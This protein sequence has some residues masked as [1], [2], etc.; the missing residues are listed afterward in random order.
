[1]RCPVTRPPA[2][3]IVSTMQTLDFPGLAAAADDWDALVARTPEID[4]FCTSSAWIVSA[5]AAFCPGARPCIALDGQRGVALM[6]LPV[7]VDTRGGL[8]LEAGWGLAAPLVGP[9][10]DATVALL[11]GLWRDAPD[12]M[13]VL[14]L[15]GLPR[16]GRWMDALL[17]R[18][19]GRFR[20]GV[21]TRCTR[22]RAH[23]GDGLDGF[24]ARRSP[25][26]RAN[27]RRAVRRAAET[28]VVYERVAEGPLGSLYDRILAVEARSWKGLQGDGIDSGAP[29]LFYRLIV[30]RLIARGALRV[31]FATR[32]GEDLAYVLGGLFGDTYRGLQ[33]SY[34]EGFESDG[35][36]NLVQHEMIRWLIEEGLVVYDLGTD[37]P[38]K[39]RWAEE[40]METVTVAVVPAGSRFARM[41]VG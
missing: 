30:E 23:I 18:F 4:R 2:S 27:L 17:R 37:M 8:P 9:D 35:P 7:G 13:D 1:M 12:P 3:G 20:V 29:R 15:S 10:P 36:G 5:R 22:R 39:R 11:D 14:F 31:V 21:G 38:Y 6:A 24:F 41:F 34:V 33:V 19:R 16:R 28:G 40:A 25:K 26:F 32:D